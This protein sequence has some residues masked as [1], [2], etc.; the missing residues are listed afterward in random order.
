MRGGVEGP[1]DG[2]QLNWSLIFPITAADP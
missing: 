2:V 1:R